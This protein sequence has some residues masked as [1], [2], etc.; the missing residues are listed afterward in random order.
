MRFRITEQYLDASRFRRPQPE[1]NAAIVTALRSEW[2]G[3]ATLHA[4][5]PSYAPDFPCALAARPKTALVTDSLSQHRRTWEH[6]SRFGMTCRP[7]LPSPFP[8]QTPA[9]GK[10]LVHGRHSSKLKNSHR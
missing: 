7:K 8:P 1:P 3:V 4:A 2:H 9:I 6:H 10:G 5:G